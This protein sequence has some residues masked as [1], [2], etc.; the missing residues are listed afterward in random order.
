[1]V[2]E[3]HSQAAVYE[4]YR[5]ADICLVTSLHD[6]MNLVAKEFV[7]SRD[8][9]QGV[10]LLSTFAGASRELLEALIVNPLTTRR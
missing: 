8:D 1:M 7:A 9:E 2:A 4:L 5:A 10:L 3:H 6:G